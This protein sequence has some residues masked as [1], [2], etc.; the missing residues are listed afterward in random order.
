MKIIVAFLNMD[1]DQYIIG[2]KLFTIKANSDLIIIMEKENYMI[3]IG[4]NV[5]L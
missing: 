5:P 2:M 4:K 3:I 1:M